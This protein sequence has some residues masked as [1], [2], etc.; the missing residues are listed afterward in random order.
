M[1]RYYENEQIRI[2][3]LYQ[4]ASLWTTWDSFYYECL[5][6]KRFDVKLVYLDEAGREV[7]QMVSAKRF[8]EISKLQY[9]NYDNFNFEEYKPHIVVYQ[10][11]YDTWHR[12]IYTWSARMKRLGARIV[13]IPYGIEIA[14]TKSAHYAHFLTP[15]ILNCYRLYTI[16]ENMRSDYE[17]YCPN[18]NAV[19]A[20]GMPRFDGLY[21]KS[22]IPLNNEVYIRAKGRKIVLWKCHFPKVINE[23]GKKVQ[24]TPYLDEYLKFAQMI[25]KYEDLFFIFMPHPK[26]SDT[27]VEQ[28]SR[29]KAKDLLEM[30]ILYENV[31]I[32]MAD[33][34]RNSLVNADAIIIDRSA[35]MVEAGAL[36]VPVL[37]MFNPDYNEPLTNAIIPLIE[38]YYKGT[39]CDDIVDFIE[40]FKLDRDEKREERKQAFEQCIPN[41]DGKCCERIKEDLIRSLRHD[42]NP[43]YVP[44]DIPKGARILIFGTGEISKYMELM[45]GAIDQSNMGNIITYIDN[46]SDRW[47]RK[48]FGKEVIAPQ[49]IY[50]YDF[51][52]VVIAT[53]LYY[54]DILNQLINMGIDHNKIIH[55]DMY[56][57]SI[58]FGLFQKGN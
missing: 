3:F 33:D 41:F 30:L 46:N 50:N 22:K 5:E 11:P 56:I 35:V 39:N 14:D 13:Y 51:D 21:D 7:S 28:E 43:E 19:K 58:I 54:Y 31:Y 36:D 55:F 37:Y 12:S 1:I 34:Y 48:Y 57:I 23:G 16:S 17:K 26:F 42:D 38:T 40:M 52:I 10:T 2:V 32:D 25:K 27:S 15:V 29:M 44:C 20:L 6:D 4:I 53:E 47:G 49:D 8:L 18:I 24:V 45:N 9:I